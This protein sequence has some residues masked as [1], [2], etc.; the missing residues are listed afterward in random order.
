[1]VKVQLVHEIAC[2]YLVQFYKPAVNVFAITASCLFD[3][4]CT[5]IPIDAVDLSSDFDT[6]KYF[7]D[8][9]SDS[10]KLPHLFPSNGDMRLVSSTSFLD[11]PTAGRLE[12][13]I[14]SMYCNSAHNHELHGSDNELGGKWGTI[15]GHEF[16]M[17]EAH[18][19]CRQLGYQGAQRW[20]YSIYSE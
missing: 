15:C 1:M 10:E 4:I 5:C 11:A 17:N 6:E 8:V 2:K 3:N 18:V 16:S 13:Y 12:V 9:S 7:E 20:N 19:A 14:Q